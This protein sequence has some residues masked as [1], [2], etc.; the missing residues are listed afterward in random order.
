MQLEEEAIQELVALSGVVLAYDDLPRALVEVCRIAVRAVP[1]A[2]GA[3]VTSFPEGRPA[4]IADGPWSKLLDEL[5][6]AEHEGPCLDA[7][8]T[9]NVFRVRDIAN[10]PRWSSY[11]PRATAEGARS[12]LSMPMTAMGKVIGALNIYSREVDAFDATAA[13]I[14]NIVAAHAGVASQVSAAYFEHRDLAQQLTAAMTSR[15][16][17]E[18]AKGVIIATERCDPD[19]AFA[20][21][22]KVSQ[23]ANRKLRDIAADVVRSGS[24]PPPDGSR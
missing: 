24:W 23:H 12:L 18:Q 2:E 19:T 1:A 8:R 20:S 5:Q 16:V 17:I 6:Y 9:G 7:F 4:A 15:A 14:A 10:D 13:S 22:T 11:L 3:S 21:L